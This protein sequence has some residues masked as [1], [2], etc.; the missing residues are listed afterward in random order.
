VGSSGAPSPTWW[1]ILPGV[2]ETEGLTKRYGQRDAVSNLTVSIPRGVI[3]GFVGPN[4]SGKTTTIRMLLGLVRPTSGTA[5][6]LGHPITHPRRYLHRIGA[7][8]EGPAFYPGLSARANLQ[9]LATL[10]GFPR[11]RIPG[12][13]EQVGLADRAGDRVGG[14]SLG[15]KQRLGVAAALLPEPELL[16]LDEPANGL[17]PPGI[18]EMRALMRSLRDAGATIFVSSHLL[19]ELEQVADWLVVLKDG[20]AL[21]A[22]PASEVIGARSGGLVVR[23]E[24]ADQMEVVERIALS[25]GYAVTRRDGALQIAAPSEFAAAL[26]RSCM[27]AEVT[28]VEIHSMQ[29]TLEESFLTMIEGGA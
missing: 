1:A 6:V 8:I 26:N 10:G 14:Y 13:L 25:R 11:R 21:F 7:L 5:Q 12:L 23:P 3:A 17:D 16:I 27:A 29:A 22:G 9:V 19:G 18:H 15:M 2:I 20:T 28:L 4:G 24:R